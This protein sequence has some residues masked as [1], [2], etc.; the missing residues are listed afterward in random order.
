MPDR[1]SS[2]RGV[3]HQ[4]SRQHLQ[5]Y[6]CEFE[7][8]LNDRHSDTLDQMS[9]MASGMVGKRLRYA[10]LAAAGASFTALYQAK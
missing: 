3:Y 1:A 6:V 4:M 9:H 10:D 8:R 2:Y 7:G 5:R